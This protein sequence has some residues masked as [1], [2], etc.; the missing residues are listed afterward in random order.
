V[1][2]ARA[3][4]NF[5]GLGLGRYQRGE[6]VPVARIDDL[7]L[8]ACR[9]IKI[10]VEGMEI[11]VLRGAN[12][13]IQQ[14]QPVLYVENDRPELSQ[15]LIEHIQSLGY[16]LYWHTPRM[17]RAANFFGNQEN[18]FANIVSVNMLCLPKSTQIPDAEL[19]PINDA[20]LRWND[21]SR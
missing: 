21:V 12:Q 7:A 15:Q 3:T 9:L 19:R 2:D 10:D 8:T 17:Y 4:T 20:R 13:T 6:S 18:V 1:L 14:F 16:R 5:G 11:E